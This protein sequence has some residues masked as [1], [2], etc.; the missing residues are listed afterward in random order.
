[1]NAG[2]MQRLLYLICSDDRF[3]TG[4]IRPCQ[5][6]VFYF[7]GN[8][9]RMSHYRS[10]NV[11]YRGPGKAFFGTRGADRLRLPLHYG[12]MVADCGEDLTSC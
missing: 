5:P 6:D 1:M 11:V 2:V 4:Q 7:A 9:A 10:A 8:D 3:C 12:R